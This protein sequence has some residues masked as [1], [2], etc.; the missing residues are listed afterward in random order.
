[1]PIMPNFIERLIL[2][3]LNLGP[4]VMLDILGAGAFLTISAALKLGVFETLSGGPLPSRLS[5]M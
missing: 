3:K 1:M 2:L 4:G 5:V